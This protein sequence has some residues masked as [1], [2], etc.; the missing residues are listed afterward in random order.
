[1]E[2]GSH[3]ICHLSRLP[4]RQENPL[5]IDRHTVPHWI[6]TDVGEVCRENPRFGP[7]ADGMDMANS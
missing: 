4:A 6:G 3:R 2:F 1:M 7:H 5:N